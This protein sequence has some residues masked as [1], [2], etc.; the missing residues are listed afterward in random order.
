[1]LAQA[2][3]APLSLLVISDS[4]AMAE[5]IKGA[6]TSAGL[7][8]RSI[9]ADASEIDAEEVD[10]STIVVFVCNLDLPREMAALRRLDRELSQGE[11]VVV[12]P[13]A[14]GTGVR[15]VLDAGAAAVVFEPE[16]ET[17]LAITIMA[18]ASG[19]SVV[20]RK[21]R[22]SV[23]RPAFSHRERQVLALVSRG[24]TNSEIAERLLLAQS[25]VKSHLS[26]AFTKL[27]I[28]SRKEV[29]ALLLDP[30]QAQ[31]VGLVGLA[32]TASEHSGN[33]VTMVP[34]SLSETIA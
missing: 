17:T 2:D 5:R 10:D 15:R 11:I 18:V 34:P 9:L 16:I 26:S 14:T 27:G 19:Q 3:S 1:M 30:E 13:P 20:P 24:L 8:P 32:A 33:G 29:T 7:A 4:S 22:A 28:R 23:E 12:S 6:F 31:S 21:L 25:T